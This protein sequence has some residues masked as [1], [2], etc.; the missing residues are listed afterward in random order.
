MG[1]DE[2]IIVFDSVCVL[3]SRWLRIVLQHDKRGLYK[4]AGMQGKAGQALLRAHGMNPQDP[5]SFLLV[6]NGVAYADSEAAIRVLSSFGGAWRMAGALRFIPVF[7]RDGLYRMIARNRYR[8]FGKLDQCM[9]PSRA[10][11][12]RFLD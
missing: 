4:F 2:R 10:T 6:E 8:W 3:C 5:S 11:A 1:D 7:A 12:N 9:V